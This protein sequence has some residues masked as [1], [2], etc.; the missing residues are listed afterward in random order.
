MTTY[1]EPR[2]LA[3]L[4]DPLGVRFIEHHQQHPD[5]YWG[6]VALAKQWRDAGHDACSIKMLVEVLRWQG[7]ISTES[8]D[9]LTLNNSY[10]AFYSRL[11]AA[12]EPD[13]AHLFA[14]RK[15]HTDYEGDE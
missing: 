11:I 14:Y 6:L 7:G 15:Q 5:I 2:Q 9:G 8:R 13:L 10:A 3:L 12:N 4:S 1:A